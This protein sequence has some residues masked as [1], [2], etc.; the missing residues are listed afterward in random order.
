MSV[1]SNKKRLSNPFRI[2][3]YVIFVAKLPSSTPRLSFKPAIDVALR[4]SQ[5][6]ISLQLNAN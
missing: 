5:T 4:Q 3:C 1:L 6:A 2:F